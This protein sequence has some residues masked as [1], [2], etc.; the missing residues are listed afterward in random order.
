MRT[1]EDLKER[2]DNG[3]NKPR[4]PSEHDTRGFFDASTVGNPYELNSFPV[5]K[6]PQVGN[7]YVFEW[8]LL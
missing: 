2:D 5:K 3:R 8:S 7:T 4:N 1:L 6:T